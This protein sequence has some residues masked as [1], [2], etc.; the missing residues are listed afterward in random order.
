MLRT[1]LLIALIVLNLGCWSWSKGWLAPLNWPATSPGE[2]ERLTH[3]FH[4]DALRVQP[5][6]PSSASA[7]TAAPASNTQP[8]PASA[9]QRP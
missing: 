3:Q 4:P 9:A 6:P 2:P 5:L 1:T 8:E 7:G